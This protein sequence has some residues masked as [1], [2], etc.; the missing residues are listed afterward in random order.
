MEV[1]SSNPI[2]F[3]HFSDLLQQLGSDNFIVLVHRFDLELESLISE[4]SN[5][6]VDRDDLDNLIAKVHQSAGSAAALG[7]IGLQKQLNLMESMAEP[8][9]ADA[10]RGELS[11]LIA[12]WQTAKASLLEKEIGRAHV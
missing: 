3:D 2:N 6:E 5:F 9:K 7:I 12:T 10:V 11:K 1:F 8:G 4:I